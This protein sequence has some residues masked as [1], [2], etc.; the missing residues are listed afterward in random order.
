MKGE[1]TLRRQC[2]DLLRELGI[3]PP[4]DVE[5]LCRLV[6]ERQGRPIRLIAQPIPVPGPFGAWIATARADYIFFQSETTPSHQQHIILHEL[7]HLLASHRS[8][9]DDESMIAMLSPDGGL[10]PQLVRRALQRTSYDTDQEREAE[11]I[12]SIILEWA[13]VAEC[14]APAPSPSPT[15]QRIGTSLTYRVGWL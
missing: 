13:S 8:E 12:A 9:V 3:H 1:R 10:P 5:T 7:G 4:L 15:T 14:V 6:G 2:R 11:T